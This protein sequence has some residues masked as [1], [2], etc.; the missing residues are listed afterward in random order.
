MA[1]SEGRTVPSLRTRPLS[2]SDTARRR[3]GST[4]CLAPALTK[5]PRAGAADG[6]C[7]SAAARRNAAAL[8]HGAFALPSRH[9][10]FFMNI[11]FLVKFI[12]ISL[13]KMLL[14]VCEAILFLTF[15]MIKCADKIFS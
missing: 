4:P 12:H 11:V 13:L 15:A 14:F 5:S 1:S 6:S 10:L 2:F 7:M 8:T 3:Q 9:A